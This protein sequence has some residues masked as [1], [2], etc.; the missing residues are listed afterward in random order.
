MHG[1]IRR[2]L[3]TGANGFIGKN[4]TLRLKEIPGVTPMT[5]VRG[6]TLEM[7][8]DLVAK[9]T[10]I[11]HLAG[12]NRPVDNSAF[13]EINVGLTVALCEAIRKTGR[14]IPLIFASS[15][16][17][18]L[19]NSYGK[20]K[21]SAELVLKNFAEQSHN[22]VA[23]FR[24][25]NVFG[26]WSKPNYNSVVATFCHNIAR[27]MPI[28][29]T[30]P[31]TKLRLVYIDD[32]VSSFLQVVNNHQ[33]G[34][35]YVDINPVYELTLRDLAARIKKFADQRLDLG[36]S[37]VG[38]GLDRAL[39]A[40]YVSFLPAENFSYELPCY[41]DSRGVF[42]EM[43]KTPDCGQISYFS[44]KPGV[45]RGGHYHHTKTEK[46]LVINGEATFRF[47]HL[48]TNEIVE[49]QTSGNKPEIVD[50]IPGWSH[51]VKNTGSG[52]LIVVVWANENFDRNRPDT[53][54]SKVK[55]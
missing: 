34:S 27:G 2:I 47:R 51:D 52:E 32:V 41:C 6:D 11:I 22:P 14:H 38:T 23:I 29:I 21:L 7:L 55:T 10:A 42:V 36:V 26:K 37:H 5:F 45:T 40:T 48:N 16:Q 50:T 53:V 4:L 17:A 25:P 39:Y 8:S 54:A 9:S 49:L 12:E 30:S 19:D 44:A 13:D 3:V 1:E 33:E 31:K 20:S 28:K 46:F 15:S 43:L 18:V 35:D 24:L